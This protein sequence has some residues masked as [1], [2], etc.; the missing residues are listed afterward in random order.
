MKNPFAAAAASASGS[1][2]D[3]ANLKKDDLP[4]AFLD[5]LVSLCEDCDLIPAS[6]T[7]TPT[8]NSAAA[9]TSGSTSETTL[10]SGT[11]ESLQTFRLPS[12]SRG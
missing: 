7:T 11:E 10:A 6:T 9:T 12:Q 8:A 2:A 1:A 4:P 5:L 3:M